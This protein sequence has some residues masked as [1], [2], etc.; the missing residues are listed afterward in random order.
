MDFLFDGQEPFRQLESIIRGGNALAFV[1]SGVSKHAGYPLWKE[2]VKELAHSAGI[3]LEERDLDSDGTRLVEIV[4]MC[5]DRL[6][7]SRYYEELRRIFEPSVRDPYSLMHVQILEMP[8]V[9]FPTTNIDNCHVLAKDNVRNRPIAKDWDVYPVFAIDRLRE[10]R[11][12]YIHGKVEND[13]RIKSVILA[14]SEYENAYKLNGGGAREFLLYA[15]RRFDCVFIG[16]SMNDVFL[17]KVIEEAAYALQ[18]E[19]K[20]LQRQGRT[21]S[22]DP[23]HF[24]ILPRHDK[25]AGAGYIPEGKGRPLTDEE[26]QQLEYKRLETERLLKQLRIT[27]LYY[28]VINHNH[29][30]LNQLVYELNRRLVTDDLQVPN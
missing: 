13:D 23:M 6:T 9:S 10:R 11:I 5:K 24:A 20:E 30:P 19:Q 27:P 29:S 3:S 4:Q 8:F 18:S 1:G 14:K 7:E 12:L 17:S 21:Q 28:R 22:R 2:L 16:Y 15:L 26:Q 25:S